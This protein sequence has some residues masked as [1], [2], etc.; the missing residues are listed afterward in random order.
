MIN[1]KWGTWL[2]A[3][4]RREHRQTLSQAIE[5]ME[6]LL[7]DNAKLEAEKRQIVRLFVEQEAMLG[8]MLTVNEKLVDLICGVEGDQGIELAR[9][10]RALIQEHT[11]A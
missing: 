10:A 2:S 6:T 5:D 3:V 1:L 7:T 4:E 9:D 11:E 8:R